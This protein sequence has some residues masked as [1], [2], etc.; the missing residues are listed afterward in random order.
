VTA[1]AVF[2]VDGTTLRVRVFVQPRSSRPGVAGVHGD[3]LRVRVAAP[4]EGGRANEEVVH[5]LARD[6]HVPRRTVAVTSG[7]SSRMKTV[8]IACV[9]TTAA[10]AAISRL[11]LL[12]QP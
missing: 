2:T 8:E 6:L 11:L 3:A 10:D 1:G 9:D 4:P 5:L 7:H 12:P